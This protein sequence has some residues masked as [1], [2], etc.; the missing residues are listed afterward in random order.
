MILISN[1]VIH[2][3]LLA[4]PESNLATK[5]DVPAREIRAVTM[6]PAISCVMEAKDPIAI[7]AKAEEEALKELRDSE[8]LLK[9]GNGKTFKMKVL[10][11]EAGQAS[12]ELNDLSSFPLT[13][14]LRSFALSVFQL[15]EPVEVKIADQ[16]SKYVRLLSE[17]RLGIC[18]ENQDPK[19][20]AFRWRTQNEE[21][22][23]SRN[24]MTITYTKPDGTQTLYPIGSS[25][26]H[27]LLQ[28][29]T[30]RGV[31]KT[32]PDDPSLCLFERTPVLP[33]T[34]RAAATQ[35]PENKLILENIDPNQEALKAKLEVLRILI[36]N[37]TDDADK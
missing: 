9:N 21:E 7:I 2:V 24:L 5:L 22:F 12:L 15:N 29:E 28:K 34:N 18:Q 33:A 31:L 14:A 8:V 20:Y 32:S 35:K 26:A 6:R 17:A 3:V 13:P 36:S 1:L 27:A 30:L 4:Q 10:V 11:D 25:V 16:K 37:M 19:Q 23:R